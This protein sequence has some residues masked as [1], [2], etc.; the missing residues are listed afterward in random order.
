M[1]DGII[2]MS[3]LNDF[4][5]CPPSIYF[6]NLMDG[7]DKTMSQSSSKSTALRA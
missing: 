1:E 6:H 7:L 5:F 2:P 4:T 3:Y